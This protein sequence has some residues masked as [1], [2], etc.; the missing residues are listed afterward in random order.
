MDQGRG[1]AICSGST[2]SVNSDLG[3]VVE[4][5]VREDLNRRHR[6][7]RQEGAGTHNAE[8]VA[9]I[10]AG[11][12]AYVL[13]DVGEDLPPFHYAFRQNH[14]ALLEEDR[15]GRFLCKVGGRVH[16]DAHVG[17]VQSRGIIDPVTQEADNMFSALQRF[18]DPLLVGRREPGED[19]GSLRDLRQFGLRHL[20]DLCAQQHL[21]G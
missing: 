11:A 19:G 5:G 16:G 7:E 15:I 17:A 21:L 1:L 20:L 10:G 2:A 9:E 6:H 12:H 4:Q 14:Q 13:D 3:E 18:D 8:H